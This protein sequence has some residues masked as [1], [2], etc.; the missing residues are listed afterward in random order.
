M[1]TSKKLVWFFLVSTLTAL[2]AL[3]CSDDTSS[4]TD[5]G[6]QDSSTQ[7]GS[8][9]SGDASV[10]TATFKALK[11]YSVVKGSATIEA[12]VTGTPTKLEL[13]VDGVAAASLT[14]APW[15][16]TWDSTKTSDGLRKL[17][18]KATAG[19]GAKTSAEITVV[20][21]NK[22]EEVTWLAGNSGTV[23]VPSTGYVEQHLKFHW[24]MGTGF[25][26][27][28]GLLF[29]DNTSDG[30]NLELALGVGTCP[31][32]GT[33]AKKLAGKTSP[34]VVIYPDAPGN[35]LG[36][37]QWFAHVDLMN[38]KDVLGKNTPFNIKVYLLK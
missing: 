22:G 23:T 10:A 26:Q 17:S 11:A 5:S 1:N 8:T 14:A 24:M 9:S 38:P 37:G 31:H 19:A 18:L 20:V 30:F 27:A 21:L 33:T 13:L 29:F 12:T 4:G 28:I 36:S 15:S 25:K 7:D 34:V 16:F 32:S 3:G 6:T 35:A 2:L